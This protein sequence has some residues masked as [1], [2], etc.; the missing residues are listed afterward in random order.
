[1]RSRVDNWLKTVLLVSSFGFGVVAI[2]TG[3]GSS[4]VSHSDGGTGGHAASDGGT[5]GHTGSGG[6][7][8]T[9]GHVGTGGMTGSGGMTGTGGHVGTGGTTGSGGSTATD[10]GHDGTTDV[11]PD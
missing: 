3:C 10:A 2:G 4:A 1:M 8:G 7:T 9:G 11:A 5:G 6:M